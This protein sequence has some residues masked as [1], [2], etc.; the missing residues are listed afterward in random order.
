MLHVLVAEVP[1]AQAVAA[2]ASVR[3][4]PVAALRIVP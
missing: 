1:D 3:V 4:C 2:E